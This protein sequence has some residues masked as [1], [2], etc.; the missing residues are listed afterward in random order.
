MW[1]HSH[2]V[3]SYTKIISIPADA[4]EEDEGTNWESYAK[5]KQEDLENEN[6]EFQAS[7]EEG[8]NSLKNHLELV[9][10]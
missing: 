4:D 5:T 9:S 10:N 8:E 2:Y 6:S 7:L 3:P 1:L